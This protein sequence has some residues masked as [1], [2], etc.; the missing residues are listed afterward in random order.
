MTHQERPEPGPV[1]A[2]AVL[3]VATGTIGACLRI[4]GKAVGGLRPI[5]GPALRPDHWPPRLQ[6]L[7][8]TGFRQRRQATAE[9]VRLFRK[10]A[11]VVVTEVLDQ[12]DLVE[13]TRGVVDQ[14]DLPEII[15]MSTGSV[16]GETVRD[17]RIQIMAADDVVAHWAGRV[18][19]PRRAGRAP[20]GPR[21]S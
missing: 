15:R 17:A 18:F 14:L 10:V 19:N 16:A 11:P 12:L 9:A 2:D 1:A 8:E 7:A 21:G 5:L 6:T 20:A 4:G 13:I 3:A